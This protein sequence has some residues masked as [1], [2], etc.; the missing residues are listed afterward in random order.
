MLICEAIVKGAD[1][2]KPVVT[3]IVLEP[4]QVAAPVL[5]QASLMA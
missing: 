5:L 2:Y 1:Q 3:P 4:S